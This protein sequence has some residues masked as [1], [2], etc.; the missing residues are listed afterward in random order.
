M[1][2]ATKLATSERFLRAVQQRDRYA[3]MVGVGWVGERPLRARVLLADAH[4][5]EAE[6]MSAVIPHLHS[7]KNQVECRREQSPERDRS[8]RVT[9]HGEG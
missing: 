4:W 3:T 5:L 1:R 7:S 9:S 2:R 6:L 8:A